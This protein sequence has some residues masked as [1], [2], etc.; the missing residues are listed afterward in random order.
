MDMSG[1]VAVATPQQV[2]QMKAQEQE[3]GKPITQAPVL[4][5]MASFV[6][7]CWERAR[8]HKVSSGLTER[9][10]A[11]DRQRRGEYDPA[12]L[13]EIRKVGGS[14]IYMMLTDIKCRAALA[15]IKDIRQAYGD[16]EWILAPTAEPSIDPMIREAIIEGVAEEARMAFELGMTQPSPQA[17]RQRIEEMENEVK[18]KLAESAQK[19]ADGMATHIRDQLQEGGWDKAL[20]EFLNDFVTYPAAFIKGPVVRRKRALKW[21]AGHK[22]EVSTSAKREFYRVS[23][24]DSFPSPEATSTQDGYFCERVRFTMRDLQ[25]VKGVKGYRDDQIQ[26]V[27]DDFNAGGLRQWLYGDTEKNLLDGRGTMLVN[28]NE[29]VDG[30]EFWGQCSGAL[31]I[32]WGMKGCKATETYDISATLIGNYVIRAVLNPDPLGARPYASASFDEIPGT[33]WGSCPPEL[34]RDIQTMCNASARALANNVAMASGP[35]V[36]ITIDRLADGERVTQQY[37]WRQFQTTSDK[38]GGGQPAIRYYQPN[39][40]AQ[41]LLEIFRFFSTRADEVTGIP[42]YVYGSGQAG[43]AGRTAQG[44]SMLMDNASKG[45]KAAIGNVDNAIGFVITIMYNHNMLYDQ[46]ES[47]KGDM[48]IVVKGAVGMMMKEQLQER[49]QGFLA[50]TANP[51]DAPIMGMKGRAYLLGQVAKPLQLDTRKIV[52]TPDE[53]DRRAEEQQAQ[54]QAQMEQ[55]LEFE[56]DPDGQVLGARVRQAPVAPAAP[57]LPA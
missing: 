44:L 35:L 56:R 55:E 13:Q 30:I 42:N 22:P 15:W 46:D 38:T 54:Q 3:A 14:E 1:L 28:P 12:K 39:M 2:T 25:A 29:A 18:L 21:G 19:S 7:S 52:P 34:M 11:C 41:E 24:Y 9:L 49:R 57:A 26:K 36:E 37:P 48:Q 10:L 45:I 6:K 17:F 53:L 47:I 20:N 23:P 43:G 31:L 16:E 50:A 40:H 51:I 8:D 33:I 32:D 5:A 27:L 4:D